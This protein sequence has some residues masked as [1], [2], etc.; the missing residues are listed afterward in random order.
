MKSALNS[1]LRVAHGTHPG[2]TGKNNEDNHA[3]RFYRAGNGDPVTLA[4]VADGIGGHRAG[5]V[6][7]AI[8]VQ[9]ITEHVAKS[10]GKDYRALLTEAITRAAKLISEQ[11]KD[12]LE[13]RGMGSTCA[14]ALVQGRR[15]YTAYVGDSR[16]YL[17]RQA[18][19][20]QIT[21]DHTWVQAAVDYGLINAEEAR[22][23]PNQH[24]LIKHLGAKGEIKP[25]FRLRLSEAE[26]PEQSE[27]NQGLAL[28]EGDTLLLCSD[29]LSDLVSAREIAIA[30]DTD[31]LQKAVDELILLARQSGGHDNITVIILRV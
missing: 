1:N 16:I 12:N 15:L 3:V 11:S 18:D 19:I 29:G 26:T 4:I 31:N 21:V 27:H 20:R 5:E 23:H 22:D 7:S 9:I 6:A 10:D 2:E 8:A 30:L 17:L 25:D 14:V 24:V 13:Q 28:E